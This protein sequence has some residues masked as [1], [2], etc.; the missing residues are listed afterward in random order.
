MQPCV[1]G[2]VAGGLILATGFLHG[3]TGQDTQANRIAGLIKQLGDNRYASREAAS[4]GL[5][6]IGQQALPALR[7]AAAAS[8]DAEIRRRAR[9]LVHTIHQRLPRL[10]CKGKEDYSVG[11]NGFTRY[12]L[13][14]TNRAAYPTEWF[15][16]SP[17][18]PPI[19]LN[20][21]A[22]RTIV[23]IYDGNGV[24]LYGFCALRCGEHLD[25][26]WFAVRQ[27]EVPPQQVYIVLYDRKLGRSYKSNRVKVGD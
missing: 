26:L 6:A 16:P 7:K 20:K 3:D 10:A 1:L 4:K 15:K 18:L 8:K 19:G 24:R 27:G 12:Q 14:V 23:E 21:Q 22:S 13:T 5:E 25:R 2:S 17:D 11:G 9:M